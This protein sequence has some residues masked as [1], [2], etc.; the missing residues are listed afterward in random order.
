MIREASLLVSLVRLVDR[1]PTPAPRRSRGRPAFYPDRLFLQALVIMIVRHL[2]TPHELRSVL[3]QP[4]AEMHTLRGMM[5]VAGRYPSRW[6]WHRRLKALPTT[7][8]ARIG[9]LGR[10]LVGLWQPWARRGRAAAIDGT[11]LRARDGVW[12]KKHREK[13]EVP[14]TSID[15]EAYWTKSGWHGWVYGWKLHLACV[16]GAVWIPLAAVLTPANAADDEV[17]PLLIEELPPE[18]RLVLPGLTD[19][20]SG[21]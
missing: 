15:T 12:H 14:H 5:T 21:A 4:T 19:V 3:D 2:H 17:A 8:R 6:T 1:I 9:C 18:A 10:W 7:L 16:V 11:I 20:H 13:G